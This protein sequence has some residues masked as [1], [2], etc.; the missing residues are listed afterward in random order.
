MKRIIAIFP[1]RKYRSPSK[2]NDSTYPLV[3]PVF[4]NQG[5]GVEKK[6]NFQSHQGALLRAR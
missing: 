3:G 4:A 2:F 5:L 1:S 6:Y